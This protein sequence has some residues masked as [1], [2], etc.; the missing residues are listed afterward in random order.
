MA[1]NI[2][3]DARSRIKI[4]HHVAHQ[5]FQ[6]YPNS[7]NYPKIPLG[8]IL[9]DSEPSAFQNQGRV[10]N[11]EMLESNYRDKTQMDSPY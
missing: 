4:W 11:R 6:T 8:L 3:Q 2:L 7:Y 10:W 1:Y 5:T 9:S